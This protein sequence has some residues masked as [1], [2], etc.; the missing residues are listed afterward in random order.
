[1]EEVAR[2]LEGMATTARGGYTPCTKE[3]D[4]IRDGEEG[5]VERYNL[6][7]SELGGLN[8][9]KNKVVQMFRTR[10]VSKWETG[11]ESGRINNRHL[12]RTATGE[13][14][15]FKRKKKSQE[16]DTAISFAVD[17]SAS[18]N[19]DNKIV[20]AT[21]AV[22]LFMET[23][24]GAK[25]K[26]EILGYTT[27]ARGRIARMP[28]SENFSRSEPLLTLVFKT[29][30]EAFNN[31]VKKKIAGIPLNKL[32][33]NCDP[34]SIRIAWERLMKRNEKRKV[35]FVLTDGDLAF[36]GNSEA[37]G[38]NEMKRVIGEIKASGVELIAIDLH[39]GHAATYYPKCI[40]VTWKDDLSEKIM[41]ALREVL[42][43]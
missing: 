30:N 34:E 12:A 8:T 42:N 17:C 25:L 33:N 22:V 21:K 37:A 5:P 35:L 28:G 7:K 16:L 15:V 20:D 43:V 41:G 19:N 6:I 2:E 27:K 24:S 18:M 39:S 10:A 4:E 31:K 29:F 13:T 40:K 1:M 26:T 32:R 36:W 9:M 23:L 3:F 38:Y 14:K 11:R